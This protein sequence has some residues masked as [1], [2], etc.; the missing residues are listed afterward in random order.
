MSPIVVLARARRR[1][2]LPFAVGLNAVSIAVLV[3][4][5]AQKSLASKYGNENSDTPFN[6]GSD[7][8]LDSNKSGAQSRPDDAARSKE[9]DLA[10]ADASSNLPAKGVD[11]AGPKPPAVDSNANFKEHSILVIES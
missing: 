10:K 7:R 4:L 3:W 9:K 6:D 8:P 1:I 11:L 2:L 5:N